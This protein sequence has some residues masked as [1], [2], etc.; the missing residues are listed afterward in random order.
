MCSLQSHLYA[1]GMTMLYAAAYNT[2]PSAHHGNK[3]LALDQMLTSM[4]RDEYDQRASL[5]DVISDCAINLKGMAPSKIC[6][7]LVM[8]A[9]LDISV[10]GTCTSMDLVPT[11]CTV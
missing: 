5:D 2:S 7:K 4:T 9:K 10:E 6:Q 3:N 1:L 11:H 8:E